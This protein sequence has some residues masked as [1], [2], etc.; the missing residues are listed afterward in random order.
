MLVIW[1]L[2]AVVVFLFLSPSF[3]QHVLEGVSLPLGVLSVLGL[4]AFPRR[5]ALVTAFALAVTIPG[6]IYMADWLRDTVQQG[7]QVRYLEPGER[8]ALDYLRDERAPGGVLTR[9]YMGALVPP[10]TDRRSWVAHPS[11]TRDFEERAAVAEDLFEGELPAA[12]AER[13]VRDSGAAFVLVDCERADTALPA[14]R[15]LAEE[16]RR[17]GCAAVLRVAR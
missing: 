3:P 17:F 10:A 5:V 7:G 2:A 6:A 9:V 13:L 11:W 15:A 8:A 1:P 16:E 12:E 14:L 4:A